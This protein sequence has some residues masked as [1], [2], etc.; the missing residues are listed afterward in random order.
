MGIPAFQIHIEFVRPN[1]TEVS[2]EDEVYRVE[3][4]NDLY[5][6]YRCSYARGC[7]IHNFMN[8]HNYNCVFA[9]N[10]LPTTRYFITFNLQPK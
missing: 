1:E 4:N 3:P 10:T 8:N 7:H 2:V 9:T 5:G 6:I